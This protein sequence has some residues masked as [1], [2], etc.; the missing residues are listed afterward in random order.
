MSRLTLAALAVLTLV[1]LAGPSAQVGRQPESAEFTV[2]WAS[3]RPRDPY[4]ATDGRNAGQSDGLKVIRGGSWR[5][6]PHRARSA[7]R[8]AYQP[9]QPVVNVGFRVVCEAKKKVAAAPPPG[10]PE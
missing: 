10:H 7:F 2:P 4:V 8:L 5:D 9:H 3:S 6:R 1:P